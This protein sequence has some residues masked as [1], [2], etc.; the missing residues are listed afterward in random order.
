MIW[1]VNL[2]YDTAVGGNT[3][4]MVSPPCGVGGCGGGCSS[5]NN[6]SSRSRSSCRN[7]SRSS[8]NSIST[9][10]TTYLVVTLA[11]VVVEVQVVVMILVVLVLRSSNNGSTSTSTSASTSTSTTTSRITVLLFGDHTMG[12]RWHATREHK[13]CL[14]VAIYCIHCC[15]WCPFV[16]DLT[17]LIR[18]RGI[19]A[20]DCGEKTSKVEWQQKAW[21]LLGMSGTWL[22][23]M[24]YRKRMDWGM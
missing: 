14:Y 10:S 20:A 2:R 24:M 13:L 16:F 3:Q 1:Y 5:S 6:N 22:E 19:C 9:T 8:S 17:M 4:P 15:H 18:S 21:G 23:T 12:G 11:A 7:T